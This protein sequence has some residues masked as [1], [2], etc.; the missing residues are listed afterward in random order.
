[1]PPFLLA[2]AMVHDSFVCWLIS[3]AK[4]TL[5]FSEE[6]S[7]IGVSTP[8]NRMSKRVSATRAAY[9]ASAQAAIAN[10]NLASA[11]VR[12][13]RGV[14][15][16]AM[17]QVLKGVTLMATGLLLHWRP[18]VVA[19]SRATLYPLL[20][21]ATRGNPSVIDGAL[22]G[23]KLVPGLLFLFGFYLSVVGSGLWHL[24][25]WARRTV[26]VTCGIT[27]I[28]WLRTKLDTGF[29]VPS[30]AATASPDLQSFHVLLILDGLVFLYLVRTNIGSK[31]K[32]I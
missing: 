30:A 18:E 28:L 24:R 6:E 29:F 20:F 5:L 17:L 8:L 27:L 11:S 21:I 15:F 3:L 1:M 9:D 25:K 12:R 26:M 16:V 19:S 23:A 2:T 14:K 13:P 4:A 31:F 10:R 32:A 7:C 22:Q